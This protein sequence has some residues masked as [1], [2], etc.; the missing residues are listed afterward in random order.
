MAA[1]ASSS[2]SE[3]RVGSRRI[4]DY[5]N[6]G[7]ELGVEGAVGTPPCTP[8]AA[9][10]AGDAARSSMM[11]RFR[12]PR[13]VRLGKKGGGGGAVKGKGKEEE[14]EEVVVE[15]GDDL[16]VVAAVSSSGACVTS[17]CCAIVKSCK[18]DSCDCKLNRAYLFLVKHETTFGL[19]RA[20]II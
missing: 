4:V 20:R 16:P 18:I 11:P 19:W 1:A 9:V 14:E 15:K 17:F 3:V 6:D 7:E 5:L 10:V 12:W 8:S 13:L 2:T